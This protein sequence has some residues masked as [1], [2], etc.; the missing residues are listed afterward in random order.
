MKNKYVVNGDCYNP[1]HYAVDFETCS[2]GLKIG[3]DMREKMRVD[4]QIQDE[5]QTEEIN[6]IQAMFT[7]ID[8]NSD[9]SKMMSQV[10]SDYLDGSESDDGIPRMAV[11][12]GK[13]KDVGIGF[14][15]AMARAVEIAKEENR[16][17]YL[18]KISGAGWGACPHYWPDWLFKAYP[19]GRTV[20][21]PE[22]TKLFEQEK[23]KKG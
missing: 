20:L 16:L 10:F 19:G 7:A 15:Q 5:R 6:R 13:S 18:Y 21:S 2:C 17:I 3:T 9:W 22:G 8:T 14:T 11:D 4:Q 1:F 12:I 23:G